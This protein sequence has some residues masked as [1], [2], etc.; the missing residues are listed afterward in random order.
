[1]I[2][3]IIDKRLQA[4]RCSFSGQLASD[5]KSTVYISGCPEKESI[6][7]SLMS[8]KVVNASP[9][10]STL[11]SSSSSLVLISSSSASSQSL[12]GASRAICSSTLT[13]STKQAKLKIIFSVL[14]SN[15]LIYLLSVLKMC[16]NTGNIKVDKHST[17]S[18]LRKNKVPFCFKINY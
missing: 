17:F 16:F 13:E 18:D 1:M 11:L 2:E 12:C 15:C 3:F 14:F 4:T 9:S 7:I 6:D 5:P 10:L 8:K